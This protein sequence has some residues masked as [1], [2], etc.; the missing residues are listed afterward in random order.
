MPDLRASVV[1]MYARLQVDAGVDIIYTPVGGDPEPFPLTCIKGRRNTEVDIGGSIQTVV[2][3]EF[4]IDTA[5]L[6]AELGRVPKRRDT[7]TWTD[8]AGL[9]HLQE[10]N[11]PGGSREYDY[12]DQFNVCMRVHTKEVSS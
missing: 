7:I 2:I 8:E 11:L 3:D 5:T 10:V 1:K 12:A 4:I 6:L 9:T